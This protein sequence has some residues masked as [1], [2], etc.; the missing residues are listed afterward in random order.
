MRLQNSSACI[1]DSLKM[2]ENGALQKTFC[3][4]YSRTFDLISSGNKLLF[5]FRSD[6][7]IFDNGFSASFV[8]IKKR[9][10]YRLFYNRKVIC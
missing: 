7:S 1:K 8:A 10:F 2:Y 4:K 5:V 9:K 3:G 6:K